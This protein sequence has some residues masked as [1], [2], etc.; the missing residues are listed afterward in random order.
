MEVNPVANV[1]DTARW[2]AVYRAWESARP[3]ALFRDP[4]AERLAGEQGRA[5]AQRMAP[6]ARNGWPI[7][8]RT[9]IIDDLVLAALA[10]GCDCVVNL[11]AGLDTRPYRMELPATLRWVEADLPAMIAEK[12]RVLAGAQPRCQLRRIAVDLADAGVRKQ[13]LADAIG[14]ARQCL[15]LAAVRSL[16]TDLQATAGIRWWVIDLAS[17]AILQMMQRTM[18]GLLANAPLKFAPPEGVAFFEAFGWHV[19]KVESL[20]HAAAR[21]RRLPGLLRLFAWIPPPDPRKLA[22][23]RW[24]GIVQLTR[25]A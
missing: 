3:D 21:F 14:G 15:V 8:A 24:S 25:A 12:E 17:P 19:D 23:A 18:R 11:A 4:F 5:S 6:S 10:Q 7:I 20:L 22:R 13:F 9:R 2:V 1:S 16:A